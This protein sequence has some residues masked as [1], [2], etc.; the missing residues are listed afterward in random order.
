[1]SRGRNGVV[2]LVEHED[3]VLSAALAEHA[4]GVLALR[5][6]VEETLGCETPIETPS[7]KL[8]EALRRVVREHGA[9][10]CGACR[11]LAEMLGISEI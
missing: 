11:E 4:R 6:R 10:H 2:A 1:M 3:P 5:A 8:V 7:G 9:D